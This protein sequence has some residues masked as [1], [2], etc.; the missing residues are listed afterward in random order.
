[1]GVFLE[2]LSRKIEKE[3]NQER[4][5]DKQKIRD[6]NYEI[7][8]LKTSLAVNNKALQ[9]M[10]KKIRDCPQNKVFKVTDNLTGPICG[11][12]NNCN[13]CK[14]DYFKNLAKEELGVKY[15]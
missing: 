13:D 5:Q 11:Q 2:K 1:M 15:D 4:E 12:V 10:S 3:R 8:K 7:V 14:V 9:L 6:L